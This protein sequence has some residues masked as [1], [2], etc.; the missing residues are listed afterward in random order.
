[1]PLCDS[2]TLTIV[3]IVLLIY[4]LSPIDIVWD[5]THGR[6]HIDDVFLLFLIALAIIYIMDNC[7]CPAPG[8]DRY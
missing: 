1:M 3:L 5:K 6:R 7:Q 8:P 2:Q 4:V